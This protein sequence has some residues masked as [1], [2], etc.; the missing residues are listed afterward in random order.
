MSNSVT[1]K[2]NSEDVLSDLDVSDGSFDYEFFRLGTR[3]RLAG[4]QRGELIDGRGGDGM[5]PG[6]GRSFAFQPGVYK[7]TIVF[8]DILRHGN[9]PAEFVVILHRR[10][11]FGNG[12]E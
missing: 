4:H 10:P 7:R 12:F 6:C 3:H 5:P 1:L 2:P 9:D 8:R 11:L